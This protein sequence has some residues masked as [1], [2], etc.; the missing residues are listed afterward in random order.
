MIRTLLALFLGLTAL[1]P[2]ARAQD[3]AADAIERAFQK[4]YAYL[5]AE[6]VALEQR[7][8][9]LEAESARKLAAA[10]A[11][12]D[13]TQSRLLAVQR[14]ADVTEDRVGAAERALASVE[15]GVGAVDG[16]L[17]QAGSTLGTEGLPADADVAT[18]VEALRGVYV[19]AAARVASAGAV[20]VEDGSFFLADGRQ[21]Q[22]RVVRAGRIAAWGVAAEGGGALLPAGGGD[23]QVQPGD[24]GVAARAIVEG[25]PP[26]RVRAFLFESLDKRLDPPAEKDFAALRR[27]GGTIG[28]VIL[29]LGVL[30]FGL[31]VWRAGAIVRGAGGSPVA[32]DAIAVDLRHG[33]T[34][35]AQARAKKLGGSVGRVVRGILVDP[36]RSRDDLEVVAEQQLEKE[37]HALERFGTMLMVG[38]SVAPL[39]GLLGTVSGMIATFDI[40]TEY[41][42]GNPKLLSGGISEALVT[43]E[44]GLI[45]AIPGVLVGNLL[46]ARARA[47]L[48]LAESSALLVL[49]H[50]GRSRPFTVAPAPAG[51]DESTSPLDRARA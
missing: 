43:T 12:L 6:K 36:S 20:S 25:T 48:A 15:E 42:A 24:D 34:A 16:T 33:R 29:A 8:A 37:M 11:R 1:A 46:N 26:T 32:V 17:A 41:G 10:E 18:R 14:E 13:A 51:G 23:L 31:A 44:F 28:D 40:I 38:A 39:L 2:G 45:V 35:E 4:E 5:V 9:T 27:S 22:G 30:L 7:R 19:A 49:H 50:L 3:V 21:V 47:T